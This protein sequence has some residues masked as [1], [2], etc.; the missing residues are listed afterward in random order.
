MEVDESANVGGPAETLQ[1][2][3]LPG[4]SGEGQAQAS[5]APSQGSQEPKKEPE[6]Q[7]GATP[8]LPP[9]GSLLAT[10]SGSTGASPPG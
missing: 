3:P 4:S 2:G 1:I 10:S 6:E 9:V 8:D 7:E 5:A